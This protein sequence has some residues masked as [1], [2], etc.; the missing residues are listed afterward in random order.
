MIYEARLESMPRGELAQ[1]QIE[2]LQATLRRVYRN[3]AYYRGVF[4]GRGV[5][6]EA[7]RDLAALEDLPFTSRADLQSSYPYGM[8]AVPL[9]D[10]VRLHASSGTR[11]R[12]VV[13]GYT[14]NDLEHWSALVARQLVGAGVTEHDIVQVTFSYSLFTGGLGF[15]YGAERLGAAV[16]PAS[17]GAIPADQIAIMRDY[18]TTV[19]AGMP[20][21]ALVIATALEQQGLHPEELNLR[22]GLFGAEPW[23]DDLRQRIEERLQ[24]RAFDTYGISEIMGPGVAAECAQRCGLHVNEDHFIVEVIDPVTLQRR[25]AGEEG[26]LV[27]TT[28]TKEGF[29]LIRYRTGDLAALAEEPCACGR[30]S[31]RMSRVRGRTDDLVMAQ[32]VKF[33]P[34]QLREVLMQQRWFSP[35]LVVVLNREDGQDLLEVRA[36]I[37]EDAPFFDE[38][39]RVSE[40]RDDTVRA[41]RTALG[42]VVELTFMEGATLR[43][44]P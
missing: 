11:G 44:L 30:T 7:V 43:Q 10:I 39:S 24:I 22:V 15:H 20:S 41:L 21:T 36:A 28:I 16:V 26:E 34:S 38:I 29:P 27:F 9:R 1:L 31:V 3:V 40:L 18:K 23:S 12:P 13:V 32:G 4:D 35:H 14:R 8:F 19:L 25:R 33:F 17:T 37:S 2:R 6:V 42:L 5:E